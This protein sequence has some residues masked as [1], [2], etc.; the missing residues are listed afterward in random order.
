MPDFD[1]SAQ[2]VVPSAVGH[3]LFALFPDVDRAYLERPS[4]SSG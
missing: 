4:T 3:A 1:P 2:P